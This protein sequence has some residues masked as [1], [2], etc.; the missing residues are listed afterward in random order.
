MP[1]AIENRLDMLVQEIHEIKEELIK[2]K[3][4]KASTAMGRINIWKSL[5]SNISPKWDHV[6]AVDEIVQQR[7]KL[8]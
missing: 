3:I 5:G 6:K 7:E 1:T 8:G 2:Q 4:E